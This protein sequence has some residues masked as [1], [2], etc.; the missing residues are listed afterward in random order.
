MAAEAPPSG[1]QAAAQALAA[2]ASDGHRCLAAPTADA[3]GDVTLQTAQAAF[4]L[5]PVLSIRFD[6][7]LTLPRAREVCL[8]AG[9]PAPEEAS[10]TLFTALALARAAGPAS[11]WSP[12]VAALPSEL[13]GLAW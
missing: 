3:E 6:K 13:P 5:E 7:L 4:R 10:A 1:R 2:W 8:A 12:Y 11:L 9:V